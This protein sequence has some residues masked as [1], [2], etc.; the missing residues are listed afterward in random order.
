MEGVPY[1]RGRSL[2]SS[3]ATPSAP[4]AE[5][6]ENRGPE[7]KR[8]SQG[9]RGQRTSP[10]QQASTSVWVH[11][12]PLTAGLVPHLAA[13]VGD[14]T[15][16]RVKK[17]LKER[18]WTG[19][20]EGCRIVRASPQSFWRQSLTPCRPCW[21]PRKGNLDW[22]VPLRANAGILFRWA[23]SRLET[24][25]CILVFSIEETPRF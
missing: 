14:A 16:A 17:S 22:L 20:R 21:M 8:R 19:Q 13:P 3:S 7:L 4:N 10:L 23:L 1:L 25:P 24:G 5:R 6:S 15:S 2:S 12:A 11:V 9:R 18:T